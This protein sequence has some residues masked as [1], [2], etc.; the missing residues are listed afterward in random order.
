MNNVAPSNVAV[1]LTAGTINE[2][3]STTLNGSFTDPG[4][5]DTH[6]VTINWGDGNTQT[7]P[8][9][10]GVTTFSTPHQ[11]LQDGN[12]PISVSVADNGGGA[13]ASVST[14]ATVNNVAPS[15]VAVS[16]TAGTINEN[17]ST[18][19]NG[20]F[21]DPGTLDTHAVTINWGDGNTQTVPLAAGVVA[22]SVPHQYLQDGN[23]PISVSVADNGGGS[24][25]SVSTPATVNNVAPS[26]VVVNV[27]S[28][29]AT[30]GTPTTVTGT[31]VDPG[32]LDT[33][34]VTINWGDG[35][36]S[37]LTLPPGV[38]TY[39]GSHTYLHPQAGGVLTLYPLVFRM[40]RAVQTVQAVP[41]RALW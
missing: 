10:A 19:L 20:S 17:G 36:T 38:T 34:T 35:T 24:S 21:T 3:G 2:N 1:S 23:Y 40:V 8:L 39:S 4:T 31:F 26:N 33:H 29:Y 37:T 11:Y 9:A 28:P 13:S 22:F 18:T 41:I 14:P 15:N 6:V 5:L 30:A 7:V 25:A 12:Y 32:T 27:N 16:L